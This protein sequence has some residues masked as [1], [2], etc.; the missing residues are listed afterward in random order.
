ME[1]DCAYTEPFICF[2]GKLRKIAAAQQCFQV[3]LQL[4]SVAALSMRDVMTLGD[5]LPP[6]RSERVFALAE[7]SEAETETQGRCSSS[8]TKM[9]ALEVKRF[10]VLCSLRATLFRVLQ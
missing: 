6:Q 7:A 8:G 3:I 1:M 2:R 9:D 5:L 4:A 10:L